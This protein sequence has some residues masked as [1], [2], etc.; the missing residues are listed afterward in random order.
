MIAVLRPLV[1]IT[2]D[3][4][5][6]SNERTEEAVNSSLELRVFKDDGNSVV[7]KV[8]YGI[9]PG[10]H[11]V[12]MVFEQWRLHKVVERGLIAAIR[13]YLVEKGTWLLVGDFDLDRMAALT[14]RE[15]QNGYT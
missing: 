9:H 11:D 1:P 12:F 5:F 13:A 4:G 3:W 7:S 10:R 2:M 14:N 6:W 15:L 8:K